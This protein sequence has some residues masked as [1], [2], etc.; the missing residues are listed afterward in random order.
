MKNNKMDKL[1]NEGL[2]SLKPNEEVLNKAKSFMQE[3]ISF[4]EEKHKIKKKYVYKYVVSSF[5]CVFIIAFLVTYLS[6]VLK[7]S[8]SKDPNFNSN[9]S[10]IEEEIGT[11]K[12][13]YSNALT[14]NFNISNCKQYR[15]KDSNSLIYAKQSY[16]KQNVDEDLS[17]LVDLYIIN[18]AFSNKTIEALEPY[19]YLEKNFTHKNIKINYGSVGDSLVAFSFENNSYSYFVVFNGIE[20]PLAKEILCTLFNE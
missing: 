18:P 9:N 5:I 13:F 8:Y 19:N 15:K 14:F 7:S 4:S 12:D 17:Y 11:I 1:L 6:I 20:E 3:N 10:V 16:E 2:N